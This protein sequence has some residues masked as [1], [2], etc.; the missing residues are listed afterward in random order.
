MTSSQTEKALRFRA[1][2]DGPGIFVMPNPWD[3]GSAPPPA[4]CASAAFSATSKRASPTAAIATRPTI[5][6]MAR[7]WESK[8]VADQIEAGG[9]ARPGSNA[10]LS[11]PEREAR[12]Q[13][14]RLRLARARVLRELEAATHTEHRALLT[15]ALQFLDAELAAAD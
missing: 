3:G 9:D 10:R 12:A 11:A 7:G 13:R 6:G 14:E 15:R 2:H 4:R 5:G 1:L 8:G